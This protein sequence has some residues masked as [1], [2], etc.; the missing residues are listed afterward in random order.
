MTTVDDQQTE[1]DDQH[2]QHEEVSRTEAVVEAYR[3]RYD[4]GKGDGWAEGHEAGEKDAGSMQVVRQSNESGVACPITGCQTDHARCGRDDH[5][6][7]LGMVPICEPDPVPGNFTFEVGAVSVTCAQE[8]EDP[9]HITLTVC[10]PQHDGG[11]RDTDARLNAER[12]RQTALALWRAADAISGEQPVPVPPGEQ[13]PQPGRP[14]DAGTVDLYD[15]CPWWCHSREEDREDHPEW[16]GATMTGIY[17]AEEMTEG[18]RS[19]LSA[20]LV[21]RFMHGRVNWEEYLRHRDPLVEIALGDDVI[22]RMVPAAARSL[23]AGLVQL[24]DVEEGLTRL[25]AVPRTA[26]GA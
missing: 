13:H 20:Q 6:L 12:A 10:Q 11:I 18:Q 19:G 4:A 8:R 9:P 5:F 21:Q 25:A 24:A 23:A 16:H 2:D 26:R 7:D 3:L 1:A 17:P 15:H 22:A 14:A